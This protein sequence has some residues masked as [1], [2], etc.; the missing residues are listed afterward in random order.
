MLYH[1][2][3]NDWRAD[4]KGTVGVGAADDKG[5]E[6]VRVCGGGGGVGIVAPAGVAMEI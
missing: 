4:D 3:S 6:G 1:S 2:V 5:T